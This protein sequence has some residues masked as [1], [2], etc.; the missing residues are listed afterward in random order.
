[1]PRGRERRVTSEED[2]PRVEDRRSSMRKSLGTPV[3]SVDGLW[4]SRVANSRDPL[5]EL[6]SRRDPLARWKGRNAGIVL[7]GEPRDEEQI[8]RNPGSVVEPTRGGGEEKRRR[9]EG[10]RRSKEESK[11]EEVVFTVEKIEEGS[12]GR[13]RSLP[14]VGSRRDAGLLRARLRGG[15]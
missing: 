5:A 14:L 9:A 6:A 4:A 8:H 12:W 3:V 10:D 2:R 11:D 15:G 13:T 1:M 7:D